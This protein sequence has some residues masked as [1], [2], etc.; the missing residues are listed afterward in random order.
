V[1]DRANRSSPAALLLLTAGILLPASR[2]HGLDTARPDVARFIDEVA[3]RQHVDRTWLKHLLEEAQTKQSIID[4]MSKPAEK[5]RP[6]YEYRR[7][8]VTDKRIREGRAFYFEHRDVFDSVAARTGVSAAVMVA[9]LGAE[10]SYGK[11]VGTY[12]AL[13]ALSTL[14]FDYPARAPY[15]RG[16]LE[17]FIALARDGDVDPLAAM[18]SYAGALG[19]PQFMPTNVRKF[20]LDGDSDGTIDLYTD[21]TDVAESIANYLAQHGWARGEPL[22]AKATLYDPDVE[23][24]HS[25]LDLNSTVG[26]L[27]RQGVQVDEAIPA[28][29]PA[30]FAAFRDSDGPTYRVGFKNFWVI[31]RYNHSLMYALA[32]SELAEAIGGT[33]GNP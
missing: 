29:T 14:A 3:A 27:R 13:D 24:L 20:A 33:A 25:G 26:A 15:F 23:G 7:I 21:W 17:Q 30:L 1:T 32:V 22:Y 4:T 18:S 8:F 16:E 10:T 11:S 6:W 28:A 31:T 12:R 2:V 5:V 9:I 19:A